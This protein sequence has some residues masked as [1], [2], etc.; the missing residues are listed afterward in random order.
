MSKL[1]KFLSL[2][3]I[4]TAAG[5]AVYYVKKV[6]QEKPVSDSDPDFEDFFEEE[7]EQWEE[8]GGEEKPSSVR[9]QYIK[10]A[11]EAA[12]EMKEIAKDTAAKVKEIAKGHCR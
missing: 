12:G 11:S 7:D 10:I 6:K 4:G 2:A 5:A 1:G 3:A 8:G 9:K